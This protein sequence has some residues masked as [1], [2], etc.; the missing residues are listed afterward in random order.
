MTTQVY[1]ALGFDP[2][3]GT[4]E[5]VERLAATLSRVG[6]QLNSTHGTLTGLG[7]GGGIW[8]GEAA[9]GFSKKLGELPKYLEEGHSSLLDAAAALHKWNSALTDFQAVAA[10]YEAEAEEARRVLEQ[11]K[12]NP[13]LNLVGQ[14]FD[15]AEALQNAQDRIDYASK[16]INDAQEALNHILEKAQELLQHH[17]DAARLVAEAIRRAAEGAPDEPGLFDRFMDAVGSLG[18]KLKEL[19]ESVAKWAKEHADDLYK[20]GDWLGMAAAACDVLAIVFSETV[21]GAAVF[22]IAGRVLNT[23]ALAFHVAGYAAGAKNASMTDI[24]LD[25]AGFV[26][27]GDL[28]KVGKVA[29][30]AIKGVDISADA[31]KAVDRVGEIAGMAKKAEVFLEPKKILG[32]FGEG[33][34]VYRITSESFADRFAMASHR[35]FGDAARY[36]RPLTSPVKWLDE[37]AMPKII[38]NTPLGRIPALKDAVK[39]GE[40]GKTFIDPTSWVSRAPEAAYRGYKFVES[41]ETAVS[42]EVHGKYEKYK[43]LVQRGLGEF[44]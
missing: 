31:F 42:D 43:G 26:P 6:N 9:A 2:A 18:D 4:P 36:E 41:A 32:V 28:L 38:D 37:H 7:T 25:V 30:G 11:A 23:G 15:T 1:D 20:I 34:A 5:S 13:D 29:A 33:K 40:N 14:T 19:G 21:I 35:V 8:E 16:R 44:G 22:E 12:S 39:L 24:A 17:A 3:P 27:F 10:R